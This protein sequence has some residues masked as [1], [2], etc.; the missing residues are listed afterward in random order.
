MALIGKIKKS[1]YEELNYTASF[2]G[3]LGS[4]DAISTA[5]VTAFRVRDGVD[6]SASFIDDNPAPTIV[7][8]AVNF[9]V[10][11]GVSGER[12]TIKIKI[13]LG[14]GEKL[15]DDLEVWVDN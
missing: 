4:S 2:T 8:Q 3:R 15:Q 7:G 5:S 12:Y 13:V 11:A 6:V 14:D 10:L 9:R 1:A